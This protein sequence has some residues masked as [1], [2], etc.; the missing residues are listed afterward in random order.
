MTTKH[1]PARAG[2]FWWP[3]LVALLLVLTVAGP[4][5]LGLPVNGEASCHDGNFALELVKGYM[6]A[7][8]GGVWFP[9]W[10]PAA[11]N[12]LGSPAFYFYGRLP[13]FVAAGLGILLHLGP[14]GALISGFILFRFAAFFA[15]RAWLL[16]HSSQRAA[17]GGALAFVALPFAMSLNPVT[18]VDFAETAATAGIPLLFL[19]LDAVLVNRRRTAWAA[20]VLALLYATLAVIHPLQVVLA[21]AVTVLYTLVWRDT[22]AVLVNF[23]CF[24]VGLFL[25]AAS[26]LPALSMRSMINS[27][28]WTSNY[29]LDIWNSFLFTS[30]QFRI[31]GL[32]NVNIW[33][34]ATWLLCA[35]VLTLSFRTRNV[36]THNAASRE[37]NHRQRVLMICLAIV[38]LA[39]TGIARPVWYPVK[40]LRIIQFPW[41][42]LPCGIALAGAL[43]AGWAANSVRRQ[44]KALGLVSAL[45]FAQLIVV[46]VG[47]YL[48]LTDARQHHHV[49]EA[50]LTRVPSFAPRAQR[51]L[52]AY[53]QVGNNVP[54]YIPTGASVAGWHMNA[55]SGL[56]TSSSSVNKAGS[57]PVGLN[58]TREADGTL[59][60]RGFLPQPGTVLL[61]EFYFPD[62]VTSGDGSRPL[63]M[64]AAT[65]FARLDLPAGP[66][67]LSVNH[68][69]Q[70]APVRIGRDLSALGVVLVLLWATLAFWFDQGA[71]TFR[72]ESS[73]LSRRNRFRPRAVVPVG[74]L[75]S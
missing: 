59:A 1:D 27:A 7:L 23:L 34:Y 2:G 57:L 36:A 10:L 17:D 29:R 46:A 15:C 68:N 4:F 24:T 19:A 51:M 54:E 43:M 12:G 39:T 40:P 32:S 47:G 44:W 62:E 73:T 5:V 71:M 48:S 55:K 75:T 20:P 21:F 13:F 26:W 42:L 18:R 6:A 8:R 56:L 72:A 31:W 9:H 66:V 64:D 60:L 22:R 61:P 3:T 53:T 38:L 16:P 28:G 70:L 58:L 30:L 74:K 69:A 37:R 45:I 52:P 41:R 50:L 25:A 11:N 67:V 14:V 63:S 65:G 49:P 35:A 33:L